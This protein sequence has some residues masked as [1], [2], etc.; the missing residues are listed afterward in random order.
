[1]SR[2]YPPWGVPQAK[3][4]L[5]SELPIFTFANSSFQKGYRQIRLSKRVMARLAR[6]PSCFL[7]IVSILVGRGKLIRQL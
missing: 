4:L 1:M 3:S 6:G 2:G 7:S 5:F